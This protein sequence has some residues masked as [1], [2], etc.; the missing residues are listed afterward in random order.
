MLE[1]THHNFNPSLTQQQSWDENIL[2]REMT[3]R[4]NNEFSS[5]IGLVHIVAARSDNLEVKQALSRVADRLHDYARLHQALQMPA[6]NRSVDATEHICKLCRSI[7]LS[8]LAYRGIELT[9]VEHPLRLSAMQCWQL[10]LI[11][12]ELIT[13]SCR[14]AFKDSGGIIRVEIMQRGGCVECIVA[15]NGSAPESYRP[16]KG[17]NIVRSL[18]RALHGEIDQRFG[19][20]GGKTVISFPHAEEASA[21]P[22]VNQIRTY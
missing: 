13:N 17:L 10:S 16:G 22:I 3:H 4:I 8:K 5:A 15:D 9:F 6:G 14:H 18:V 20:F 7:S 1:N 19:S 12:S 11:L 2:L 21:V